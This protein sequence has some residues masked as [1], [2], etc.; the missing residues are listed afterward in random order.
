MK[1]SLL[2]ILE[3][4]SGRLWKLVLC[5]EKK[6]GL[7]GL[8]CML[9]QNNHEFGSITKNLSSIYHIANEGYV[10]DLSN[11]ADRFNLSLENIGRGMQAYTCITQ[12]MY[13]LRDTHP[14]VN[15]K[16]LTIEQIM[17]EE[18][19]VRSI[20]EAIDNQLLPVVSRYQE[21]NVIIK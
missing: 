1:L 12:M 21:L 16:T 18:L 6:S 20:K 2:P 8:V 15:L 9:N 4:L 10:E 19:P 14:S 5:I 11:Y 17:T 3:G 7:V 13:A